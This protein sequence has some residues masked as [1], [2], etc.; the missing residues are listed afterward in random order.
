MSNF[1][2]R[3]KKGRN[4]QNLPIGGIG[5]FQLYDPPASDEAIW[6]WRLNIVD[7]LNQ[8]RKKRAEAM[9]LHLTEQTRLNAERQY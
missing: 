2:S 7:G 4:S 8:L 3:Q 5:I 6:N 9:K 1:F